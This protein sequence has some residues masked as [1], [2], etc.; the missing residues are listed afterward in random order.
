MKTKI[1]HKISMSGLPSDKAIRSLI[2]EISTI[3]GLTKKD[4]VEIIITDKNE[5]HKLNQKYR[6]IDK[7]TDVLSFPQQNFDLKNNILGSIVICPELVKAKEEDYMDVIKHGFLHL[8][9]LDHETNFEAWDRA[10]K[11]INCQL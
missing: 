3:L 7:S 8:I 2:D 5:I 9:G 6:Q 11:L 4:E 10:A 1:Y